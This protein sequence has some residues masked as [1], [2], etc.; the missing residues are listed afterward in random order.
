MQAEICL[1][2]FHSVSHL[3]GDLQSFG[4]LGLLYSTLRSAECTPNV[5]QQQNVFYRRTCPDP[6]ALGLYFS[7]RS[8]PR[9]SDM[10]QYNYTCNTISGSLGA[11]LTLSTVAPLQSFGHWFRAT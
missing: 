4:A 5:A 11:V 8:V 6:P 7:P 9:V 1:L 3:S 2:G 10:G